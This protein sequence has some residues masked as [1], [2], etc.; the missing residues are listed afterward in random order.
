MIRWTLLLL[1]LPTM[2]FAAEPSIYSPEFCNFEITFPEAPYKT[3]RCEEDNQ[4]Y[5]QISFTKVFIE[6]NATVNFRV[7]CNPI[8]KE[9]KDTYS[10]EV[11][12]ATLRAMTQRSVVD[13]FKTSYREEELYKQAGLVG[14]GTSGRTDTLYIAQ[15]WIGDQSALSVEAELI[16]EASD[17]AD[18]LFSDVLRSVGV[19]ADEEVPATQESEDAAAEE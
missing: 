2:A 5:E 8:G 1:L 18:A 10:G 17:D 13:T 6:Q 14:Q 12:R 3:Q 7:I 11:M 16:G 15:L 9:I 19:K 4:C